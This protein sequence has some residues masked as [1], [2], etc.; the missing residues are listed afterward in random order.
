MRLALFLD[1]IGKVAQAPIF[2]AADSCAFFLEEAGQFFD[3]CVDLCRR[4]VRS[5]DHDVLI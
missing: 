3:K 5:C 1:W 2:G 4:N